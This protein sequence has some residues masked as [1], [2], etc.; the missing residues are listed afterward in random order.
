MICIETCL[1][2]EN[3]KIIRN[4]FFFYRKYL[5]DRKSY[6]TLWVKKIKLYFCATENRISILKKKW[7][8]LGLENYIRYFDI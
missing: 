3:D 5:D 1:W 8:F 2:T 7:F 6:E 4:K